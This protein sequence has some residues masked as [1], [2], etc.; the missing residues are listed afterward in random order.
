MCDM[1]T[2]HVKKSFNF[3]VVVSNVAAILRLPANYIST[4]P[5]GDV[6]VRRAAKLILFAVLCDDEQSEA[7]KAS[8]CASP[9]DVLMLMWQHHAHTV[10][11]LLFRSLVLCARADTLS[12]AVDWRAVT[13]TAIDIVTQVCDTK[14]PLTVFHET[15]VAVI[16]LLP[17]LLD[18]HHPNMTENGSQKRNKQ[19]KRTNY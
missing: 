14:A 3:N 12:S 15:L 11:T 13:Q 19:N 18:R 9:T 4:E 5:M 1:R 17:L 8:L 16:D 10:Q 7:Q 2:L 6:C